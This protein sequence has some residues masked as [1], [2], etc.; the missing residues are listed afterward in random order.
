MWAPQGSPWVG[1][2]QVGV[3]WVGVP[4]VG[5]HVPAER[6][7]GHPEEAGTEGRGEHPVTVWGER[8]S[9]AELYG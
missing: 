9:S 3:P 8:A 5:D 6:G 4:Q 7:V 1:V 2:L